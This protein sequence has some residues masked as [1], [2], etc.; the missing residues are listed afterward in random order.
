VFQKFANRE[1][2]RAGLLI[3]QKHDVVCYIGRGN[4]QPNRS[5]FV[6][7]YLQKDH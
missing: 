5:E 1:D 7:M 3:F 2:A 4:D 6:M